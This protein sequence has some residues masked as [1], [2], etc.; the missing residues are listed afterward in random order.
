MDEEDIK[1]DIQANVQE[2]IE[3]EEETNDVNIDT[4]DVT[5]DAAIEAHE[6]FDDEALGSSERDTEDPNLPLRRSRRSNRGQG[7]ERL[8]MSFDGKSYDENKAYTSG[9]NMAQRIHESGFEIQQQ[10]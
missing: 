1:I 5:G 6:V 3:F 4:E 10:F 7:V 8:E 2:D 9:I